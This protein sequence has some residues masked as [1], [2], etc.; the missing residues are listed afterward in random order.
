MMTRADDED[1]NVRQHRLDVYARES[2]P[3]LEYYRG[4]RTFRSINGAQS[5]ERVA[6]ELAARIDEL[7]A[8]PSERR[9]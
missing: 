8:V 4:R 5:P 9:K 7:V 6:K 2:K 1:E 3:L